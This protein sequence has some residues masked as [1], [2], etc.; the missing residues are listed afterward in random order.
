MK[1]G[2]K[3]PSVGSAA[4]HF[5]FFL[6]ACPF[7]SETEPTFSVHAFVTEGFLSSLSLQGPR[8]AAI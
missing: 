6:S 4:F 7:A 3:V 5:F 2:F 1:L 8:A